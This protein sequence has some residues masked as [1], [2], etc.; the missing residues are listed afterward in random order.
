MTELKK[1]LKEK[2]ACFSY[3]KGVCRILK[4]TDFGEK[5]C[6]FYKTKEQFQAD[7][8]KYGDEKYGE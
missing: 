4:D 1:C 5:D 6:P 2:T 8:M 7:R 3:V